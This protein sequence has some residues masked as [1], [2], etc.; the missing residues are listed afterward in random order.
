MVQFL[1]PGPFPRFQQRAIESSLPQFVGRNHAGDTC[2]QD[3][4]L[5]VPCPDP[6]AGL[7]NDSAAGWASQAESLHCGKRRSIAAGSRYLCDEASSC[8]CLQSL[9]LRYAAGEFL[10]VYRDTR[11]IRTQLKRVGRKFTA[12]SPCGS[13]LILIFF[14]RDLHQLGPRMNIEPF[15]EQSKRSLHRAFRNLHAVP[16]LAIRKALEYVT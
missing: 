13:Q 7:S 5:F 8:L 11:K 12:V 6:L 15:K 2:A 14:Q 9:T 3:D 4:H 16:D 10:R 1:P